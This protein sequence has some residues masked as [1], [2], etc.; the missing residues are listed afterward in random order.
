VNIQQTPVISIRNL[1]KSLGGRR[2]LNNISFDVFPGEIFGFLGPNGSGKTTTIK[3]ILGLL[4]LEEGEVSIC[5]HNIKSDYEM[6]LRNVGGIVENPEMYRYLTGRQNLEQYRQM[7]DDVPPER[8]DEVVKIVR[9]EERINDKIAKYSLGMRQRLGIAQAILHRP[10]VLVLDEPTNG[11]DPAGIKE[12]RDIFKSLAHEEGCAVFV[13][14]HMLAEL[15][16]MCD[17]VCV[18][19]RGT[20]L[21][22]MTMDEIHSQRNGDAS[23]YTLETSDAAAALDIVRTVARGAETSGANV[24]F[25]ASR[26]DAAK[27]VG[28]LCAAGISVYSMTRATKSLE[29]AFMEITAREGGVGV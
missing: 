11:L 14:S 24:V 12:L 15:E 19:D 10:K 26:D 20:V 2:I 5:S 21:G 29:Q 17:R 23:K 22:M 27:A 8:I 7:Y 1:T 4:R 6:A 16:L 28:A 3:V 9:L 25:T 13:S 18:I